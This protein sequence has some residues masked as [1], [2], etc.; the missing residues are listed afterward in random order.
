MQGV[1][2][3]QDGR[4]LSDVEMT[5][6][7][8]SEHDYLPLPFS[9]TWDTEQTFKST[10]GSNGIFS[11]HFTGHGRRHGVVF[12]SESKPGYRQDGPETDYMWRPY[13]TGTAPQWTMHLVSEA[14]MQQS[15]IKNIEFTSTPFFHSDRIGLNLVDG[16]I[17]DT[18][19]VDVVFYWRHLQATT[20]H[21]DYGKFIIYAPKGGVWFWEQDRLFAPTEGY[22]KGIAF[23]FGA[24]FYGKK[25]FSYANP[26][27][28]EFFVKS[29]DGKVF[30]RVYF[31]INPTDGTLYL[32]ARA[33][34]TGNRFVDAKGGAFETGYSG[35]MSE[36]YLNPG[37][38]WWIP[39][40]PYRGQIIMPE[41]RLRMM[42]TNF[43]AYFAG[44]YQTPP[45]ILEWMTN[46]NLIQDH[47]IPQ[48]L[49]RNYTAP[50]NVLEKLIEIDPNGNRWFGKDARAVL[51]TP[52]DVKSFWRS[53][54]N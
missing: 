37:V 51:G 34:N 32:R 14:L 33:N 8:W 49:A 54:D 16:T 18:T 20:N 52:E 13:G 45:D 36:N 35:S 4:P 24:E 44:H 23:L 9:P 22:E 10:T 41:E 19:N 43:P 27:C 21:G 29:R 50:T 5:F 42:A 26:H 40:D 53:R 2:Y 6:K 15:Q 28:A 46:S 48:Y 1:V 3:D 12:M 17:S 11:F 39:I 47:Y 38:P 30:A 25:S 7:V 31:K